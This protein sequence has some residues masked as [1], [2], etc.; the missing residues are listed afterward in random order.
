MAFDESHLQVNANCKYNLSNKGGKLENQKGFSPTRVSA[1]FAL[2]FM[3]HDCYCQVFQD[4][5]VFMQQLLTQQHP[6]TSGP[7]KHETDC[8]LSDVFYSQFFYEF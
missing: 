7:Y 4:P 1:E 2:L 6:A 3:L 8:M 5:S